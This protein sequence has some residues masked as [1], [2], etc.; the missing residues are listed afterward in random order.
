MAILVDK[1]TKVI[2]QNMT[3]KTGMFHTKGG[4]DYGT[5]MVAGATP[6]KG[7]MKV[8]FELENGSKVNLR[9]FDTV[10]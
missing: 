5:Q 7:G 2:T 8:D 4:L 9:F 3:G 1:N 6:G 10:L